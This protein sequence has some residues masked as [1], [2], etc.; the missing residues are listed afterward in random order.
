MAQAGSSQGHLHKCDMHKAATLQIRAK[1]FPTSAEN[2]RVFPATASVAAFHAAHIGATAEV[3]PKMYWRPFRMIVY[4]L[5]GLAAH[6][7]LSANQDTGR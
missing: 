6:A 3:P 7:S 2:L 1:N 5:L 4:P